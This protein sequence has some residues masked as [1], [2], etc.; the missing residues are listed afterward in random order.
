MTDNKADKKEVKGEGAEAAEIELKNH[1]SGLWLGE[2]V[3]SQEFAGYAPVNPIKVSNQ[4][5]IY[6][7]S[8]F[9][10]GCCGLRDV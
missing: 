3:P 2:A 8:V 4:P 5:M 1:Y 10:V 6:L 7:H 9:I